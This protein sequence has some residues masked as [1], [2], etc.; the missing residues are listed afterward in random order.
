MSPSKILGLLDKRNQDVAL[1]YIRNSL[2]ALDNSGGRDHPLDTLE[3]LWG[4]LQTQ[5]L[6]RQREL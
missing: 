4:A 5:N 2:G 3:G 1:G 6:V